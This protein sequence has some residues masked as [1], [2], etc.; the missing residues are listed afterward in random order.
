MTP[1]QLITY[2][3]SAAEASRRLAVTRAC[4]SIW[5]RTGK[6]SPGGQLKAQADSRGKLKA[7]AS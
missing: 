5:V 2:Y 7:K 1:K 6:I 4:I 3:G